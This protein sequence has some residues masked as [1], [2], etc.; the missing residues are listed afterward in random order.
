MFFV[1]FHQFWFV[2]TRSLGA[3]KTSAVGRLPAFL[4]NNQEERKKAPREFQKL[5]K[6]TQAFVKNKL[7]KLL[8]ACPPKSTQNLYV[9]WLKAN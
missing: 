2:Y 6:C 1:P 4:S 7:Y 5:R 8:P 3:V 9:L